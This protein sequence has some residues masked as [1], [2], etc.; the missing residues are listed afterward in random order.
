MFPRRRLIQAP[1]RRHWIFSLELRRRSAEFSYQWH[2]RRSES[3]PV[4]PIF[5]LR[6]LLRRDWIAL[7][8][9]L[10]CGRAVQVPPFN[11]FP[12]CDATGIC[13]FL[14][15]LFVLFRFGSPGVGVVFSVSAIFSGFP[16]T[17]NLSA[18]YSGMGLA[19]MVLL[20]G[21]TVY[22][23]HTSLGRPAPLRPRL[24]ED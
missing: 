16:I 4:F 11:P 18:W 21:L 10:C 20:L 2:V 17:L 23:F 3:C 5:L 15:S 19:G 14:P 9:P 13:S 22:A 24:L 7:A 8:L 12:D 6:V 1:F